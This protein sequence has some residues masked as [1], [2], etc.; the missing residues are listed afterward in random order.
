MLKR[1]T[2]YLVAVAG[3]LLA[4]M[5]ASAFSLL[6]PITGNPAVSWQTTTVGL[7]F[8]GDIGGPMNRGE[9]YRWNVPV[10]YV[11][12]DDSFIEYFGNTGINEVD[13]ALAT[14]NAL[15]NFS[16]MS[17]SLNEFPLRTTRVNFRAQ[18]LGLLDLKS[19]TLRAVVEE[20]GLTEAERYTFTLRDR[21][22]AT[23]GNT[24][25]TNYLV[26][27][28][29]FDPV[30]HQPTPFVNGTLYTYDLRELIVP[31]NSADAFERPA[32]P[33]AFVNTSVSFAQ[34]SIG[35]YFTGLTR[36]DVGGLRYLYSTNNIA[37]ETLM[38]DTQIVVT[39]NAEIELRTDDLSLLSRRS[40]NTVVTPTA[41]QLLYP[42]IQFASVD[43]NL[44]LI[45]VTNVVGTNIVITPVVTNVFTYTFSNVATNFLTNQ[46][47]IRLLTINVTFDQNG[48]TTNLISETTFTTN[49]PGG[50]FYIITNGAFGYDLIE[51]FYISTNEQRTI[52]VTNT[53]QSVFFTNNL[54]E[55]RVVV[56]ATNDLYELQQFS[57]TNG[58]AAMLARYPGLLIT[59]TNIFLTAIVTN[60]ITSY[61]TNY[62]TDPVF[63]LGRIVTVTNQ[64]TNV[65]EGFSYTFGN[66]VTNQYFESGFISSVS[67]NVGFNNTSP[68]DPAVGATNV[69]TNVVVS[70]TFETHTNGTFYIVPTNLAGYNIIGGMFESPTQITNTLLAVSFTTNGVTLSNIL[71]QIRYRTNSVLLAEPIQVQNPTNVIIS[72]TG[73][74]QELVRTSTNVTFKARTLQLQNSAAMGAH[75]RRGTDRVRFRRLPYDSVLGQVINPVTNYFASSMSV[76]NGTN[77]LTLSAGGITNLFATSGYLVNGTNYDQIEVRAVTVPD[78]IFQAEELPFVTSADGIRFPVLFLRSDT[79]TWVNH[80]TINGNTQ[81]GG[82]GTIR[83]PVVIS[84]NNLGPA[85]SHQTPQSLNQS[86]PIVTHFTWGTFNGSGAE[87]VVYPIGTGLDALEN[88]ILNGP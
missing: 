32:D 21:N 18:A 62:Y 41:F 85:V 54:P 77:I 2:M 20:L 66:V 45:S 78:I 52:V 3:I 5:P 80:D 12:Y 71:Q 46:S 24:T 69:T 65:V 50:S 79:S 73:I 58:P 60:R 25:F 67:V 42:G 26:I 43:T 88:Q 56:R 44:A 4:Q 19:T 8:A 29:N 76:T 16:Q 31:A 84:Y 35:H 83:G 38:P 28:R 7:N 39:N 64:I 14:F 87:P 6:G 40:T 72:A 34:P 33:L 9:G 49:E 57:L 1:F 70:T 75:V 74:R 17:T 53:F 59:G 36:D 22:V 11:A 51:P 37:A 27:Q 68:Y 86:T 63:L 47:T 15:T 61:L 23:I 13:S 10:L 55:A 82:P 81:L 30:N 48:F